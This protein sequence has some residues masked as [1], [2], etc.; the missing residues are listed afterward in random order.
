[1]LHWWAVSADIGDHVGDV[2]RVVDEIDGDP[3]RQS[4][5]EGQTMTKWWSRVYET[6]SQECGLC[7]DYGYEQGVQIRRIM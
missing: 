1:M 6:R 5:H 7:E 2:E 3:I 4:V